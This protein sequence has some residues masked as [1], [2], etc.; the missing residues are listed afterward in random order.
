MFELSVRERLAVIILIFLMVIGGA[1]LFIGQARYSQEVIATTTTAA[2]QIYVHVCGAVA[3]PGVI[4]SKP[5]SRVFE[6]IEQ[7]G[8]LLPGADPN[9]VNLAKFVEDGEQIYVPSEGEVVAEFNTGKRSSTRRSPGVSSKSS[10]PFTGTMNLN[11]ATAK[12]LERIPGIGP[13]LARAIIE[14][15]N[16][17]GKFTSYEQL[18]K[19][20]G[21]GTSKLEKFRPYLYVE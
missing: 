13:S 10:A 14:Y 18:L 8:G 12:Q 11:T 2:E 21:I 15:R 17:I 5:G 7:A 19:V 1:V 16:Q 3:K 20:T 4:C 6:I 9:R